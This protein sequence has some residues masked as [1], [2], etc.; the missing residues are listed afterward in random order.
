MYSV[1]AVANL[2]QV[3]KGK[4]VSWIVAGELEASDVAARQSRRRQWRI[5]DDAIERFKELRSNQGDDPAAIGDE[6]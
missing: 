1:E 5:C 2:F 4:V 3:G 6:V